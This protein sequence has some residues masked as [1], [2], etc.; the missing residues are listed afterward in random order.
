M[1]SFAA[2]VISKASL[3]RSNRYEEKLTTEIKILRS[4]SHPNV[5]S[6][7]SYFEDQHNVYLLTE[8]CSNR[9]FTE[10]LKSKKRLSDAEVR[11]WIS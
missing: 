11:Y 6:L 7:D 8:L 5:V 1:R 10:L 3:K 9:S 2:K 4:L